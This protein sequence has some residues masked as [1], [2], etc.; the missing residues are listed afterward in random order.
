MVV[1][2]K[3]VNAWSTVSFSKMPVNFF[4]F[5]FSSL[6][7]ILT[8]YHLSILRA[9]SSNVSLLKTSLLLI[10]DVSTIELSCG[11]RDKCPSSITSRSW[12]GAVFDVA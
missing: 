11:N 1:S 12:A 4:A 2:C 6:N 5:N 8:A 7:M 10:Q 3:A 9:T